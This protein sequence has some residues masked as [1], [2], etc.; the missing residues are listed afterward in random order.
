LRCFAMERN[1]EKLL[2]MIVHLWIYKDSL[3]GVG[4]SW[5]KWWCCKRGAFFPITFLQAPIYRSYLQNSKDLVFSDWLRTIMDCNGKPGWSRIVRRDILLHRLWL[6]SKTMTL[7][8]TLISIHHISKTRVIEGHA[9]KRR[10][11]WHNY[12]DCWFW[13]RRIIE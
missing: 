11:R 10:E 7:S 2:I 5:R 3:L 13:K 6:V 1:L 4:L 9:R 12:R 8:Y